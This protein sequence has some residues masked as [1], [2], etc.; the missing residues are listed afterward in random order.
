[1]APLTHRCDLNVTWHDLTGYLE[2]MPRK[3][4]GEVRRELRALSSRG[5]RVIRRALTDDESALA[6]MRS[7]LVGK[8]GRTPSPEREQAFLTGV[9]AVFDPA[10]LLVFEAYEDTHPLGFALFARDGPEWTA[11]LTGTDYTRSQAGLTYFA[12]C[13][14]EPAAAAPEL[15]ITSIAY[16][17]GAVRAKTSRGAR[18][19]PVYAAMTRLPRA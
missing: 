18:A 7:Q 19:R 11:L 5:V 1:M 6:R 17:L 13:F 3:R 15:G 4:R 2:R 9:R 8:Y 12:T 10:E 14:Y 16:G